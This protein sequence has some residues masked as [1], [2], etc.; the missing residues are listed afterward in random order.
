MI[1]L[2][3][4]NNEEVKKEQ[5]NNQNTSE[6]LEFNFNEFAN[7]VNQAAQFLSTPLMQNPIWVNQLMKQ[8]SSSPQKYDRDRLRDLL[9]NPTLNEKALKDFAQYL[10]NTNMFFKRVVQYFADI[11]DFRYIIRPLNPENNKQF[12]SSYF[13]TLE[14]LDKFDVKHE[15]SKI[16]ES[17]IME[18]A[19]FYYLRDDIVD[20]KI[21]LQRMPTDYCKI[22]RNMVYGGYTYALNMAYF[23]QTGI[24]IYDYAE[25][26]QLAYFNFMEGKQETVF[27]YVNLNP[28][29]A[30]VFKWDENFAGIIPVLLGVYMN[31]ID[32]IEFQDLQRTRTQLDTWKV[33]FQRIPMKNDKDAKKNDFLIDEVNAGAFHANIKNVLPQGATVITSPMDIESVN[34]E[35][36]QNREN[37]V[38]QGEQNF[39]SATGVSPL[40]FGASSKSSAGIKYGLDIDSAFVTG[41]YNQF[42][43]FVKR[44]L[45]LINKKYKF[46]ID[47]RNATIFNQQQQFDNSIKACT[48][49][50]PVSLLEHGIGLKAGDIM[51]INEM[52]DILGIKEKMKPLMS[53]HTASGND[54]E[55][56]RDKKSD[57]ELS[58]SG[59]ITRD[60]GSNENKIVV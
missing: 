42:Q 27:Y 7:A 28:D 24:N 46:E 20:D 55:S 49:G 52:E 31:A 60:A 45:S 26:I 30:W 38:S 50:A 40:V 47:F 56:G 37:I 8:I 18:D 41:M 10:Y 44:Q 11:L 43:R 22:N 2:A 39:F 4:S 53:S 51:R 13:K 6:K 54:K 9:K 3:E 25:E 29:K 5:S 1:I 48:Y 19:A 57:E 12:K 15:F 34:F 59:I 17:V 23:L 16:M 33:L 32:I 58:D 36:A 14:W 35:N 21:T